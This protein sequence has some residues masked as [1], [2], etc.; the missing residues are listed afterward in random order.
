M[1]TTGNIHADAHVI[2]YPKTSGQLVRID[3]AEGA[4]VKSGQVLALIDDEA[5]RLRVR[6]LE[7]TRRQAKEK[8]DRIREMYE[9]RM[10]S[11]EA[12]DD[13]GYHYEDSDVSYKMALLELENTRIKSPI[14]GIVVSK[15]ISKGDLINLST[16]VFEIIDPDSLQIDVFIPEREIG[17][18]KTGMPAMIAPDSLPDRTF[19]AV[20]H[21]INP[22][23]DA[24]TG[25]VKVTL[26]FNSVYPE[27]N[28]GMF[29]RIR[30]LIEQKDATA[31]LPKRA[32]I[33]RKDENRVFVVDEEDHAELRLLTLGLENMH[34]HEVLAGLSP[35]DR[36]IVVGQHTLESG[37]PVKIMDNSNATPQPEN[38]ALE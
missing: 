17:R 20:I 33:R 9:N 29:V 36:L 14:D 1:E 21:Q 37:Q 23:V 22:A 10:V 34:T 31:L 3:V 30:I 19:D 12:Y 24:K 25:T 13:A 26:R 27:L 11:R 18:L 2:V 28:S 8:L 16:P 4:T 15:K 5:S 6:Q 38:G 35:G 7:V 32:L